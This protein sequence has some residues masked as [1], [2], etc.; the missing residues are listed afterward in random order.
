[1]TGTSPAPVSVAVS[2]YVWAEAGSA[3]RLTNAT[4]NRIRRTA[5]RDISTPFDSW[6]VES[7]DCTLRPAARHEPDQVRDR[8]PT[9]D[10]PI[11]YTG[12][13]PA[14]RSIQAYESRKADAGP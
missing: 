7:Q 13:A 6:G 9:N 10:A 3:A 14:A 8:E 1:M 5:E 2:V 4:T 11:R 12:S